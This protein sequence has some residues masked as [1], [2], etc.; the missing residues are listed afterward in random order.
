MF[1]ANVKLEE[2]DLGL[3]ALLQT[4]TDFAS[5]NSALYMGVQ[6]PDR[7]YKDGV[8]VGDVALLHEFGSPGGKVPAK[9]FIRGA[10]EQNK[11]K[12]ANLIGKELG[13][14]MDKKRKVKLRSLYLQIGPVVK[15]DMQKAVTGENLIDTGLLLRSVGWRV[16]KASKK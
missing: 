13:R 4:L 16:S 6:F 15:K 9:R 5:D 11:D 8:R 7:T 12:Y 1:E 14:L 3:T 10:F 2:K